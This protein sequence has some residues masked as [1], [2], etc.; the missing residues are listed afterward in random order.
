MI[1]VI[2]IIYGNMLGR[3]VFKGPG[4]NVEPPGRPFLIV[5]PVAPGDTLPAEH[6]TAM[7]SRG[8]GAG[9]AVM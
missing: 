2:S 3:Y 9:N 1:I 4:G 7:R 6:L 8:G 5:V